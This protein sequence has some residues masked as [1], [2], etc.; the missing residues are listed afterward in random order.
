M[1][2]NKKRRKLKKEVVLFFRDVI[3]SFTVV[4]A[5][6]HFVFRPIQVKGRSM[7]PTL[8]D[9]AYGFSNTIG[10]HFGRLKRFDVVILYLP[11]RK[12]YIVKRIVGLP[13]E[14]IEY[15]N[16][17]LLING[18]E[19]EESFLNHSYRKQY[20]ELF[21]SDVPEQTIPD[22]HYFCLG[23]NRPNSSDSRVYGSFAK[24]QIVSKGAFILYP[25][26]NFGVKSW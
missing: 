10:L 7:Y 13:G 2:E 17:K 26:S 19:V 23:D 14:I 16:S 20:G 4:M 15:K 12:E 21:T 9:G 25:F 24:S 11:E 3:I 18:K 5:L 22:N 6:M 8:E 1:S